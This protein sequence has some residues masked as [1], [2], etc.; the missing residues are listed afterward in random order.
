MFSPLCNTPDESFIQLSIGGS[1]LFKIL[2]LMCNCFKYVIVSVRDR[3]ILAPLLV[4]TYCCFSY[5]VTLRL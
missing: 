5:I 4:S 2:E 1:K 3:D